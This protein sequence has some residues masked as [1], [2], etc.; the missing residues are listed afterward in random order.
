[1][2]L[3]I[4]LQAHISRAF[5]RSYSLISESMYVQQNCGRLCRAMFEITLRRGWAQAANGTLAMAKSFDKQ[6]WPFQTPLR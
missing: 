6:V 1:M 2:V 5:I 3:I 4:S